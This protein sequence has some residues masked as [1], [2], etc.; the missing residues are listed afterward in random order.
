LTSPT[1]SQ[2]N[3]ATM[4]TTLDQRATVRFAHHAPTV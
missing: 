1:P 4:T 3:I 2:E